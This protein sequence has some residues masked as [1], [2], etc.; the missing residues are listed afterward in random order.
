[1]KPFIQITIVGFVVLIIAMLIVVCLKVEK[2]KAQIDA[3]KHMIGEL[4]EALHSMEVMYLKC[5]GSV[6]AEQYGA[7]Y[8]DGKI[9]F[10]Q[11]ND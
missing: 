5:A 11:T 10:Y 4:T 3:Q 9:K 8:V 2:H 1:M 6:K 7:H